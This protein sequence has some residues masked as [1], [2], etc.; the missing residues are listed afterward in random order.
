MSS[1]PRKNQDKPTC[2]PGPHRVFPHGDSHSLQHTGQAAHQ[3]QAEGQAAHQV[4]AEGQAAN[5]VQAEGQ[6]SH[7]V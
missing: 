1:F 6:A 4:Q 2:S 3:V 5:Q 7:Q